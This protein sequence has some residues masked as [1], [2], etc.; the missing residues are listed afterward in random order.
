V[1]QI[2]AVLLAVTVCSADGWAQRVFTYP[3]DKP[4][5]TGTPAINGSS[6]KISLRGAPANAL[7]WWSF[8]LLDENSDNPM[9][10]KGFDRDPADTK[11]GNWDESSGT[12]DGGIWAEVT[13]ADQRGRAHFEIPLENPDWSGRAIRVQALIRD[14]AAPENTML[15]PFLFTVQNPSHSSLTRF[16]YLCS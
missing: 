16:G 11:N 13:T 4:V 3:V 15:V 12:W 2:L 10:L 9:D 14:P 1:I 6:V 8:S 7:V 5:L